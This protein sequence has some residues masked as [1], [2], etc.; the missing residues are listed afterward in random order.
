MAIANAV[1]AGENTAEGNLAA[2]ILSPLLQLNTNAEITAALEQLS[3]ESHVGA[4]NAAIAANTQI[5]G[6]ALQG[7]GLGGGLGGGPGFNLGGNNSEEL[8]SRVGSSPLGGAGAG[9]VSAF[10]GFQQMFQSAVYGAPDHGRGRLDRHDTD[11]Q[12]W[13]IGFGNWSRLDATTTTQGF[14]SNGGSAVVGRTWKKNERSRW[15]V[16]GGYAESGVD[17]VAS[18]NNSEI[19]TWN[20]GLH[21]SHAGNNGFYFDG[22]LGYS[23][24]EIDS[25]RFVPSGL[26]ARADR[27]ADAAY[28]YGEFGKTYDLGDDSSDAEGGWYAQPQLALQYQHIS[29]DAF[30]ETGAGAANLAI[31]RNTLNMFQSAL[32]ARF[33]RTIR[34]DDG[35]WLVPDLRVRWGHEF[36]DVNR[37]VTANFVGTSQI[38][39]VNGRQQDRDTVQVRGG[40]TAYTKS[41][42]D[43][44]LG[45]Y[46]EFASGQKNNAAVLR[47]VKSW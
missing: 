16:H 44:D 21:G 35:G 19:D 31:A 39:Q 34:Q 26:A 4:T 5:L 40:I 9:M 45:Y 14:R 23:K 11:D 38:F 2:N 24:S 43:I 33:F 47:I 12:A 46:G 27:D 1:A 30:V 42:L 25:Q 3:P 41:D 29:E 6:A 13:A 10:S 8:A 28:A 20:I 37:D 7:G 15:G 36:G 17:T 22:A 32:G 18:P